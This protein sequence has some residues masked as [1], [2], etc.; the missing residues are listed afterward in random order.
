MNARMCLPRL[1]EK[2]M[3][4]RI[5]EAQYNLSSYKHAQRIQFSLYGVL[6]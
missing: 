1:I 5:K 2:T 6:S 3:S 4:C